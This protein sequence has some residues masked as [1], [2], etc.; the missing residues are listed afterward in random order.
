[1]ENNPYVGP[2]PFQEGQTLHGRSREVMDLID[3][4]IVN[5]IVVLHSPSGAGKTSL[6]QASLIPELEREGFQALPIMRVSLTPPR[7]L[8]GTHNRFVLSLLP[9]GACLQDDHVRLFGYWGSPIAESFEFAGHLAS[10]SVIHLAAAY[11]KMVFL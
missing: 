3:L 7:P 11:P 5:R 10:V 8:R 2:M 6:V 4:L 1:M 9:D